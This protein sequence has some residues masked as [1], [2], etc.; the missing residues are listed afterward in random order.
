MADIEKMIAEFDALFQ[1]EEEQQEAMVVLPKENVFSVV[2]RPSKDSMPECFLRFTLPAI[3]ERNDLHM[4]RGGLQMADESTFLLVINKGS[5]DSQHLCCAYYRDELKLLLQFLAKKRCIIEVIGDVSNDLLHVN[6]VHIVNGE[7]YIGR[8]PAPPFHL[9]DALFQILLRRSLERPKDWKINHKIDDNIVF[10]T[11]EELKLLYAICKGTYSPAIQ[12][13]AENNFSLLETGH[14]GNTD[15][16][17]IL[18]SL[19]Y[20]LNVDWTLTPPE[21][22]A[23]DLIRKMLDEQ[24]FGLESV[25]Q[26]IMEIAAQIRQTHSLPKWGILLSGPAGVGKTSIAKAIANILGMKVAYLDFS[27]LRDSEGLTGSYR[28]YE[29][30]KPGMIMEKIYACRTASL[31]MVLNEIDKAANGKDRGNPLD[32]LLPLL[33]GM[34]FTDTY[35][36]LSVPTNGILFVATCNDVGKISKP[37]LDRFYR[38]DIP[39]YGVRE[40]KVIFDNYIFPEAL[41][42]ANVSPKELCLSKEA[43]KELFTQYAVEPGVR[44]LE[45]FA[46]KITSNYLFKRETGMKDITLSA[47][48]IR[49]LLGPAQV[50]TKPVCIFPGIVTGAFCSNGEVRTFQVQAVL[51]PG[52]GELEIIHVIGDHQ[53]EYCKMAY[54]CANQL[55]KNSLQK[56]DIILGVTD[57]VQDSPMNYIGMVACVAICSAVKGVAFSSKEVFLGGCDFFGNLYLEEKTIDPYIKCLAGQV[58]TF[59]GPVG[60]SQLVYESH[61]HQTVN[62]VET[63]NMSVLFELMGAKNNSGC[64]GKTE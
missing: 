54:I 32:T 5:K 19:S 47:E 16:R 50:L 53:K 28:I 7:R 42:Q 11:L 22:P 56:V 6:E 33:D 49:Q 35:I 8:F 38:I 58:H 41:R 60:M 55:L 4:M 64:E 2:R 52:R 59:Y 20:I 39:A 61:Q 37:V 63:P 26:R 36:E 25:K 57:Y 51:R 43:R 31:V 29:N 18:K 23:A 44:D 48:N 12:E 3:A 14:L 21:V 46:E 1:E 30:G 40:K 9:K 10:S 27:V 15:K 62:L 17:H 45:K 24:F 13:W 34:G